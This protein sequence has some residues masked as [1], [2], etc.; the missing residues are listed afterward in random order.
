MDPIE[1]AVSRFAGSF[2]CAQSV[3]SALAPTIGWSEEDAL[4][5]AAAFGG[6]VSRSGNVCGAVS[7]A[8]MAIGL[9]YGA[10]VGSDKAAK[11]Q[12]Y[13]RGEELLRRFRARHGDV[14]C[15]GLMGRDVSTPEGRQ[16]ARAQG[17]YDTVCPPLVHYA[18]EIALEILAAPAHR[19][20]V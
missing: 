3:L 16:A 8:M 5:V 11:D 19:A 13:E 18:V 4:R 9:K 12:T 17:L 6:G 10:T 1:L 2:N 15:N 14:L 7:G 20:R